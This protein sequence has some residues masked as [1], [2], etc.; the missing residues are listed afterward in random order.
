MITAVIR[1]SPWY[2]LAVRGA[3]RLKG[4]G[5][6]GKYSTDPFAYHLQSEVPGG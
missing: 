4:Q 6:R 1:S 5:A 3:R 2:Y